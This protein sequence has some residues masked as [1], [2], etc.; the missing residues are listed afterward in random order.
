MLG[1]KPNV[2]KERMAHAV[3]EIIAARAGC[4]VLQPSTDYTSIDACVKPMSG[5]PGF[6][7]DV[8][9]KGSSSL[10]GTKTEIK[11]PLPKKN[12]DDLRTTDLILPR[13]LIVTELADSCENWLKCTNKSI[14]FNKSIFWVDLYGRPASSNST[15]V[16]ISIPRTNV[17]TADKLA[18]LMLTGFKN[19]RNGKGGL[20]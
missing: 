17:L 3:L 10:S 7:I 13:M 16:T 20:L 6:Q 14:R 1:A 19:A 5:T 2:L 12:F 8:Q 4:E 15:N 9:I 11:F 18:N